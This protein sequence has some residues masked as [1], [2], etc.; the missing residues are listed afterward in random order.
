MAL[1]DD[2]VSHKK[3]FLASLIKA[4]LEQLACACGMLWRSS[5]A[6]TQNLQR[7]FRKLPHCQLLYALDTAGR[8]ISAN[9]NR[10]QID[11]TW[12]GQDLSMR[13]Y[14]QGILPYRGMTLSAAYLSARSLQPCI[15]ALQAVRHQ[16][17][18]LG[19]IAADFSLKDLPEISAPALRRMLRQSTRRNLDN[20]PVRIPSAADEHLDYL[21]YIL[22]T[23]LQ[24][25]GIFQFQLH[26]NSARCV[27]WSAADPMNYHLHQI[28]DLLKPE[29]FLQY[30]K[31]A[32][33]T[34]ASM[35]A[36]KIP[37]VLAQFKALRDIG[38]V[39]VL[40][41]ASLNIVNATVSLSFVSDG[42]CFM[43]ADEFLNQELH[44]WL[45]TPLYSATLPDTTSTKN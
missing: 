25:H 8:Q 10:Q 20:K 35:D 16:D 31:Q 15:T 40:R 7:E 18:L 45:G 6:L 9:V 13:P 43:S 23:L 21:T 44:H 5:D 2:T 29:L 30:P 42:T 32:Y 12:Q 33:C 36:E 19:F 41:S 39:N 4:P 11:N 34:Q 37:L 26:F 14:L 27:L 17:G 28:E 24:E 38:D 3:K 1:F 22:I